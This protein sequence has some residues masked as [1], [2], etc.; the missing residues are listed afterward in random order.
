[1]A[2]MS[3]VTFYR[4]FKREFGISPIGFVLHERIRKAKQ[5]LTIPEVSISDICYQLG[6][7]DLNYFHRQFKKAEGITPKQFRLLTIHD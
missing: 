7:M 5:L 1:M 6:F 3:K 4:M 2:C